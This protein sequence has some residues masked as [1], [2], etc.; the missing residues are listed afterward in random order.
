MEHPS[1]DAAPTV[2]R[3]RRLRQ[4]RLGHG[5]QPVGCTGGTGVAGVLRFKYPVQTCVQRL[6]DQR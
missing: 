5:V 3:R 2:P 6:T 4:V 1:L